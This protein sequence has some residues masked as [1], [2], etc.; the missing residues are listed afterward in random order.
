M[1]SLKGPL[2]LHNQ[3]TFFKDACKHCEAHKS[4]WLQCKLLQAAQKCHGSGQRPSYAVCYACYIILYKCR[5]WT[6]VCVIS[7]CQSTCMCVL[8]SQSLSLYPLL[9]S[10][11]LLHVDT[12]VSFSSAL[13]PSASFSFSITVPAPSASFSFSSSASLS[14]G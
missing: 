11:R 5:I 7:I 3:C 10:Q 14:V 2:L 4:K 8:T 9:T 13:A 12:W 6:Y 1:G